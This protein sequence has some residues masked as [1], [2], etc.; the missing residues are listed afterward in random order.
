MSDVAAVTGL[1][2]SCILA[3]CIASGGPEAMSRAHALGREYFSRKGFQ[4]Q[5]F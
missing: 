5:G 4:G 3:S 2:A 1:V